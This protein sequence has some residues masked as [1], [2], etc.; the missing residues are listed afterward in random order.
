MSKLVIKI[1]EDDEDKRPSSLPRE[2]LDIKIVQ[3]S[4]PSSEKYE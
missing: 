3:W 2:N 4:G 1:N